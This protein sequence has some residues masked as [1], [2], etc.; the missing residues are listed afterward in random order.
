VDVD[1]L[2]DVDVDGFFPLSPHLITKVWNLSSDLR[3]SSAL[4]KQQNEIT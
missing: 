3:H 1:V 2:V 4:R